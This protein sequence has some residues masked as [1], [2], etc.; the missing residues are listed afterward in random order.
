[1]ETTLN[2]I[3]AQMDAEFTERQITWALARQ[4]AV[5]EFWRTYDRSAGKVNYQDL[6]NL[7]GG[8]GWYNE[9]QNN[10]VEGLTA[11]VKKVC[12]NTFKA[13]NANIIKKLTKAGVTTIEGNSFS[14][15][16]DGFHGTYSVETDAGRKTVTIQTILAGGY[17]IQCLHQRT[18]VHVK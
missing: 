11:Y 10:S 2:Q 13:R 12:A 18:L 3:F 1:M 15:T 14:R 16:T 8:K 7:A 4:Q 9:M 5:R 17:N 6:F